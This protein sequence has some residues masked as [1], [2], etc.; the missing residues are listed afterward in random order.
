MVFSIK[1]TFMIKDF[2]DLHFENRAKTFCALFLK[3][4]PHLSL[5]K[6][7]KAFLVAAGFT[8]N[9]RLSSLKDIPFCFEVSCDEVDSFVKLFRKE[10]LPQR[11]LK[12]RKIEEFLCEAYGFHSFENFKSY[13]HIFNNLINDKWSFELLDEEQGSVKAVKISKP[14][15]LDF[16]KGGVI[17]LPKE[18]CIR[19]KQIDNYYIASLEY[20]A[21]V[22][23][24]TNFVRVF[25]C[26]T[27]EAAKIRALAKVIAFYGPEAWNSLL[28]SENALRQVDKKIQKW[29]ELNNI[30]GFF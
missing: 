5:Q 7:Q 24:C 9:T 25:P 14:K 10:L 12:K 20:E 17:L 1:K 19:L 22:H 29:R 21:L 11:R 13:L 27:P 18:Q 26:S 16:T 28:L 23:R 4:F 30:N 15:Q 8:K 2:S 3:K 6:T